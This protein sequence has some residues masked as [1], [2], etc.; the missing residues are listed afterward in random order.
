MNFINTFEAS[1]KWGISQRRVRIMCQNGQIPGSVLIG[2]SW[3]IPEDAQK[4]MDKRT[5]EGKEAIEHKD[6]LYLMLNAEYADNN[7]NSNEDEKLLCDI[8]KIMLEGDLDKAYESVKSYISTCKNSGYLLVAIAI[9]FTIAFYLGKKVKQAELFIKYK[10]LIDDER[11][12]Y[13]NLYIN[14]FLNKHKNINL[15]K[16]I[17]SDVYPQLTYRAKRNFLLDSIR[18]RFYV[19]YTYLELESSQFE[20]IDNKEIVAYNHI[21]LATYYNIT[22]NITLHDMHIKKA[23]DIILPRKWYLLIAEHGYIVNWHLERF[24]DEDTIKYI[25]KLEE[26]VCKNYLKHGT[27]GRIIK[28]SE[29]DPTLIVKIIFQIAS[30]K[31]N[32]EISSN[33]NITLYQVKKYI[34]EI[35]RIIGSDDRKVVGEFLLEEINSI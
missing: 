18:H 15:T 6:C 31:T 3:Q 29:L 28:K 2:K 32:E 23:L 19:D 9:Q 1:K 24:L 20:L 14:L 12:Y 4:P 16:N 8:Q 7:P 13:M 11:F 27:T 30:N 26:T 21:L 25:N 17:S 10:Y 35:Y 34:N 5:L 33:L 22:N